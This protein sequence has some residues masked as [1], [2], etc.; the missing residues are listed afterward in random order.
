MKVSSNPLP[1]VEFKPFEL[2]LSV[3]SMEE[4][5]ALYLLFNYSPIARI[6]EKQGIEP[7]EIR[8]ELSKDN[9]AVCNNEAFITNY[10]EL[11]KK[12]KEIL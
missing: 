9:P 8:R 5:Q 2:R 11:E 6:L 12:I 1:H 10:K 4:A 7:G 3:E